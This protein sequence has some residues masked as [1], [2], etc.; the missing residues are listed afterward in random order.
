MLINRFN[1]EVFV[2]FFN[3]RSHVLF[4]HK[5]VINLFWIVVCVSL[6]N[7]ALYY[8]SNFQIYT[9]I[10]SRMNV[11]N[12]YEEYY[13]NPL[14]VDIDFPSKKKN[15]I[16]IITE[17]M[18]TNF[19]SMDLDDSDHNLIENLEVIAKNNITFSH[20]NELG[21][22]FQV[23][24]LGWTMGSLVGQ[25]SGVPLA[26]PLEGNSY[27]NN[28]DFLPGLTSIGEV[29]EKN[30]Y[31]NYFAIGSEASFGGRD[32]YFST[33]GNYEIYDLDYWKSIEKIEENYH[34]FWGMEDNKLFEYSKEKLLE[35]SKQ[36]TPFNYTMLTVDSHFT[37][38]YTDKSCAND[39]TIAY[40]N[41]IACSD[42]HISSFVEWIQDQDFYEDTVI[43]IVG[44]HSTMNN[45]FLGRSNIDEK[46]VYNAFINTE[47]DIKNINNKYR[48]F[49]VMDMFPTT[50]SALGATIEGDR[51]GLGTNLFSDNETLFEELGD[52]QFRDEI[53]LRSN[54][55]NRNFHRNK[56]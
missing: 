30:D 28:G 37:D 2:S 15:L 7:I 22:P 45:D 46:T 48:L 41:A 32:I 1:I 9:Y 56:Q 50:L 53:L 38:G 18:N 6:F 35:I 55:Y 54:Y 43:V 40:A 16:Y 3:L 10:K 5:T 39:F 13:I 44:D 34:V 12:L 8:N 26:G 49:T 36:E 21:G 23:G 31:K 14:D 4:N 51:L 52:Q 17:S 25:T 20:N 29:L 47:L 11:S 42:A 27:G 19:S 33:H 24:G